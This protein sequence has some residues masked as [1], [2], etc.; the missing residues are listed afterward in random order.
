MRGVR[1]L[2]TTQPNARIHSAASVV[3]CAAAAGL[4]VSREEWC[5][6]VLA[7]ALVWT[8]EAL[9]TAL[10][11]LADAAI[12]K[13]HELIARAKDVAA[14]GVL[15]ASLGAAVVGAVVFVPHLRIAFP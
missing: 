15:L 3:V 7:M 6:L 4:G 13:P 11:A 1:W 10:E 14:G 5:L 9:N 2:I 8:A 12:Q